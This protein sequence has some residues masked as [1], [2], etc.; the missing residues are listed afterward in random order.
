MPVLKNSAYL[1]VWSVCVHRA[2]P[3]EVGLLSEIKSLT[4]E[5]ATLDVLIQSCRE[6]LREFCDDKT[7]Q[8]YPLVN[9]IRQTDLDTR[10]SHF[11]VHTSV[12]HNLRLFHGVLCLLF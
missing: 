6:Q 1:N 2:D 12:V 9:G 7:L 4:E 8:S 3:S 5:E 11:D 10:I